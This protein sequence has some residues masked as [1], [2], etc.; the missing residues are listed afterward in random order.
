MF[1]VM[2]SILFF[3]WIVYSEHLKSLLLTFIC[4][5]LH[6]E[7]AKNQTHKYI[8]QSHM[9]WNLERNLEASLEVGKENE[10]LKS[11]KLMNEM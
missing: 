7:S 8:L 10:F 6:E 5:E 11:T 2:K 4:I 9:I 3:E 1:T